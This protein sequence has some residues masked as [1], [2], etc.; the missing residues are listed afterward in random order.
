MENYDVSQ[1]QL[2]FLALMNLDEHMST[3][4][5]SI[6]AFSINVDT[7]YA[8]LS[9]HMTFNMGVA[10]DFPPSLSK[11]P[12]FQAPV[13]SSVIVKFFKSKSRSIV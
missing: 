11:L 8:N 2:N 4:C 5:M 6:I 12:E 13:N 10:Q 9:S 3:Y 1:Q 7:K